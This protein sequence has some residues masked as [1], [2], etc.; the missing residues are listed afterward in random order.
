M[1]IERIFNK[2][3]IIRKFPRRVAKPILV[4]SI[5]FDELFWRLRIYIFI[6]FFGKKN[7]IGK[8]LRDLKKT[9]VA[10]IPKFYSDNEVLKIKRECVKQ[11]DELPLEKLNT[12]EYIANL[13]VK[14]N[15]NDLRLERLG[16]SIKLKGL[17]HINSFFRSIGRDFKV[18]LINL[19]YNLDFNKPFLV[20]NITH[21][22]S[23]V[24]PAFPKFFKA[25]NDMIAGKPHVD[26]S[27]HQLRF[28][29]AL[30]D[31]KEENGPTVCY[32]KSMHL[33]EI[34]KNH[35]NLFLEKFNFEGDK[36]GSHFVNEEKLKLLEKNT[37]KILITANKG[38][39][40]L[41]DLKTVHY[42]SPLKSGERHILWFY[43]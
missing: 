27:I 39:L 9:G 6:L 42:A 22:G 21:D 18:T 11:L 15:N 36:G 30:D 19:I 32:K 43:Y 23:F 28:S 40:M 13:L 5:F 33:K 35:Q 29:L 17:H 16:R 7:K 10:V 38:D 8:A 31:I 1:L 4:M 37:D 41:L 25:K 2:L 26:C 14:F 24:H 12:D 34:K 3:S 20:Y